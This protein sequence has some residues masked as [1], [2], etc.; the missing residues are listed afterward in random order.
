MSVLINLLDKID[1]GKLPAGRHQDGLGLSL[2][3]GKDGGSRSWTL[4]ARD[5]AGVEINRGLGSL[6]KVSLVQARLLRDRLL[7]QAATLSPEEVMPKAPALR[8]PP[9]FLERAK[10]VIPVQTEG[11]KGGRSVYQWERSLLHFAKPLH[12]KKVCDITSADVV[13]VLSPIWLTKAPTARQVR[14]HIAK[15]FSTC[16]ADELMDRNPAALA[17]NL[18]HKLR[19]QKHRTKNHPSMPYADVP[20]YVAQLE[21]VGTMGALALAFTLLTCVRSAE[22]YTARWCDIDASNVWSVR[23]GEEMKNGLFARVPLSA[24]AQAILG[25]AKALAA[26][27]GLRGD[28]R[29][30]I[31]P[32]LQDGHISSYTMLKLLQ[33]THP[34]LTVHGFRSSF[35]TWGQETTSIDR[36]TLEYCLHHIEGSRTEQAYMRGECLEKRRAALEQWAAFVATT[37]RPDLH[38]VA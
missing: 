16:I 25:K 30:Y 1:L 38:L 33:T 29:T 31:F 19:K 2:L 18:E 20:A 5:A 8:L 17:D 13:A 27:D 22:S 11:L 12:D 36:D 34:H 23:S 21:A 26:R 37:R 35:R 3:V 32:G 14:K 9:T 4:R 24:K 7:A 6:R 28:P 10:E 15:V